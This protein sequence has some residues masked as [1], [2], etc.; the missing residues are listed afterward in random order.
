[1]PAKTGVRVSGK[2]TEV[3]KKPPNLRFSHLSRL[4]YGKAAGALLVCDQQDPASIEGLLRWKRE[5]DLKTHGALPTV[6]L[7]NK[8]DLRVADE[9]VRGEEDLAMEELVQEVGAAAWTRTSALT[10]EGVEEGVR[11]LVWHILDREAATMREEMARSDS[12]I[13]L[14]VQREPPPPRSQCQ[15]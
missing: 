12:I 11:A 8:A 14:P 15:C 7:A 9:S 3:T 1:M 4:Y 2:N 5:L 6:L 10:G 13:Q